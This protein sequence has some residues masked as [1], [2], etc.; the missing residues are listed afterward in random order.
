MVVAVPLVRVVQMAFHKIVGMAAMRNRFM[1]AAAAMRVFRVVRSA[2]MAR[3]ASGRIRAAL[4][5]SMLIHVSG[6][7]VVQMAVVQIIDVI[8]MLNR[9]VSASWTMRMRV[10][11]VCFV[12]VHF[13]ML[14]LESKRLILQAGVS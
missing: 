5:K 4:A 14:S 13:P 8:F 3:R 9:S 12:I 6:V 11:L 7:C 10:L 1:T 2:G